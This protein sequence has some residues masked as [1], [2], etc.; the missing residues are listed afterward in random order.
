MNLTTKIRKVNDFISTKKG[1]QPEFPLTFN[2]FTCPIPYGGA[3][4]N[5]PILATIPL[6]TLEKNEDKRERMKIEYENAKYKEY[7]EAKELYENCV[8][9]GM[10]FY[11]SNPD[12]SAKVTKIDTKV[13]YVCI[14]ASDEHKKQVQFNNLKNGTT[15][16]P[17]KSDK[18]SLSNF[19]SAIR[20]ETIKIKN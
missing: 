3:L 10:V 14:S 7:L 4:C 1:T 2:G 6:Y 18:W 17:I 13:G 11:G 16:K 9:V 12:V 15:Y 19:I 20:N 8:Y 5:L